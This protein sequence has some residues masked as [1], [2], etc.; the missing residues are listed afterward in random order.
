MPATMDQPG[1]FNIPPIFGAAFLF[2]L[3]H[4]ERT[5]AFLPEDTSTANFIVPKPGLW[6]TTI[7]TCGLYAQSKILPPPPWMVSMDFRTYWTN[8]FGSR[9]SKD[10]MALSVDL[11]S[12]GPRRRFQPDQASVQHVPY[13]R[14]YLQ[15]STHPRDLQAGTLPK[16]MKVLERRPLSWTL[17][18]S[19]HISSGSK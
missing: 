16:R 4:E 15:M 1:I 12:Q 7:H 11:V 14:N 2:F 3:L 19:V 17:H 18:V 10:S 5:Q 13:A 8:P 6:H 9:F